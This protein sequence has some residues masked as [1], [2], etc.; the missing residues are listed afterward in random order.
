MV[1]KTTGKTVVTLS[2]IWKVA[3]FLLSYLIMGV[4]IT[5][6]ISEGN[7]GMRHEINDMKQQIRYLTTRIDNHIDQHLVERMQ[8]NGKKE[9]SNH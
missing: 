8:S 9:D 3:G 6:K 4:W 2:G 1:T 7:A 5:A